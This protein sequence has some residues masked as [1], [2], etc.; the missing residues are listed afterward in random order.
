MSDS[1]TPPAGSA[2]HVGQEVR[3]VKSVYDWP[4]GDSPGGLFAS[5]GD[6]VIVRMIGG[7]PYPLSVSHPDRTDGRTFGVWP[8]EIEPW[9][10]SS[11]DHRE[12]PAEK[13]GAE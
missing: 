7:F 2:F 1:K 5:Q 10:N 11:N 6:K 9:A 4:S 3:M 13:E 8:K 12:R